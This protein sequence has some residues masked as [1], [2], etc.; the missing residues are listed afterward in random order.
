MIIRIN[1]GCKKD[2]KSLMEKN[3]METYFSGN[4]VCNVDKS[5]DCEP[6]CSRTCWSKRVSNDGICDYS[7][8]SEACKFDGG[9]CTNS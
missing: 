8:N 5:L 4:P 9:D 1:W 2:F 3:S 6:S 7:C